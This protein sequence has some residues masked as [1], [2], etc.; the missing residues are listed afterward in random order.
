MEDYL[1]GR[2]PWEGGREGWGGR[3]EGGDGGG[4]GDIIWIT[5]LQQRKK[6]KKDRKMG[7]QTGGGKG[8]PTS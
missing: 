5:S 1:G 4:D 6:R 3:D 2:A 8:V 7:R